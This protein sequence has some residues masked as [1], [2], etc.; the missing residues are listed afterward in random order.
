M[1]KNIKSEIEE[2]PFVAIVVDETSDCSNQSQLSTVLRYVDSTANVQERFIGFT[3]V[4]SGKTAAA[5][6]QHVEGVIAEYNVGS[7]VCGSS[8]STLADQVVMEFLVDKADDAEDVRSCAPGFG[9]YQV[10][11]W[12]WSLALLE[13]MQDDPPVSIGFTNVTIG[14]V[15]S[16][17]N[18]STQ[19]R[20]SPIAFKDACVHPSATY[21]ALH[22]ATPMIFAMT[23]L[24]F[25]NADGPVPPATAHVVT[26]VVPM[27]TGIAGP[28]TGTG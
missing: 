26:A 24:H 10:L 11:V 20:P 14:L 27:G 13:L 17:H 4:S 6:F 28:A 3:N 8:A 5:L 16:S 2:A 23:T 9:D 21:L 1:I 19:F 22:V 25:L 7:R 18:G 15:Q 12:G